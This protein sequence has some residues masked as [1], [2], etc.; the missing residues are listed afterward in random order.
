MTRHALLAL[1]GMMLAL[2][3]FSRAC[4]PHRAESQPGPPSATWAPAWPEPR[5]QAWLP[6]V[7][8]GLSM[9]PPRW[10]VRWDDAAV[11]RAQSKPTVDA[12]PTRTPTATPT[13][14][15]RATR[16]A[17][18]T[19]TVTQGP[20]N[21]VPACGCN[22]PEPGPETPFP[23]CWPY[24]GQCTPTVLPTD[25]PTPTPRDTPPAS[26]TWEPTPTAGLKATPIT[27]GWVEAPEAWRYY[28]PM[29]L[30]KAR[31]RR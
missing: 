7:V 25:T 14:P 10:Y 29:M 26:A 27:G 5:G 6:A 31:V 13:R 24:G 20:M 3:A 4:A 15:P 19:G 9:T 11:A 8:D 21:T 30:V 1:V 18:A 2:W 16:T 22:T 23:G 12:T 17:R 28:Y